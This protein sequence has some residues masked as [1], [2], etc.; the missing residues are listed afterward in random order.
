MVKK[1]SKLLA[2]GLVF[3][4]VL[5]VTLT[6]Q[7]TFAAMDKVPNAI[8]TKSETKT[9]DSRISID[10]ITADDMIVTGTTLPFS[11]VHVSVKLS[12]GYHDFYGTSDINGDY[13]VDMQG[14]T[15][16]PGTVVTVTA[17]SPNG[18]SSSKTVQVYAGRP[19]VETVYAGDSTI[20]GRVEANARVTITIGKEIFTGNADAKGDFE[21]A[22]DST[23]IKVG[24]RIKIQATGEL[25]HSD[26]TTVVVQNTR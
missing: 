18:T 26:T 10:M 2:M 14:H 16:D 4:G 7:M 11:T 21:V 3:G 20:Y 17:T 25:G 22:V 15:Y 24:T 19:K 13:V 1:S 8:V 6:P 23:L 5:G 9:F 12:A